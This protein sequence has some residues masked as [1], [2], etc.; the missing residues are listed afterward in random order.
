M[1]TKKQPITTSAI[2]AL[3]ICLLT[4][5]IC[6][7][8]GDISKSKGVMTFTSEVIDYSK[9]VQNS[10]GVRVFSFTNTGNAPIVISKIKTSCGC[11][12]PSYKKTAVLPSETSDISVKYATDRVGAFSK[13]ITVFSNAKEERKVLK[14][15][16]IVEKLNSKS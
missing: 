7:A 10:N 4:V 1:K 13:S 5:M 6:N 12:V 15:K 16:G 9:I 14:V 3:F 8:Q 11:T 2:L